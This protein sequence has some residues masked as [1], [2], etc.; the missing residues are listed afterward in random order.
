MLKAK[1]L[2]MYDSSDI[3]QNSENLIKNSKLH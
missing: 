3:L 1:N 2:D